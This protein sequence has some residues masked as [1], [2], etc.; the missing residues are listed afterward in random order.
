MTEPAARIEAALARIEAAASARA[1][2]AERL[3][4]R[5]QLLRD[6]IGVAIA[7]LDALIAAEASRVDAG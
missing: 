1:F 7:S 6:R 3:A 4:K 2:A 5:H